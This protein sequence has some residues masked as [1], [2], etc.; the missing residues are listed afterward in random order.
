MATPSA[1]ANALATGLAAMQIDLPPAAQ[2]SLVAYLDLLAKWNRT[3]NLTA[4]R[5]PAA[6]V[7]RHVLDSL[8]PLPFVHGTTLADLGSGAG[9]PGIPLAIARPELAVTLIESN[10]KKARFLREAVRSLPLPNVT[11]AEARVQDATGRFDTVTARAFASLGDMLAW[12]GQLLA[13]GG[14]WLALKGHPDASELAAVPGTFR[15]LAVHAL[16]VPGTPGGRCIVELAH[17]APAPML[18]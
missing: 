7:P 18:R 14:R 1:V 17:A 11:V 2:A 12:G 3:Y 5:D 13:E 6:M 8:A 9:L 15:V 4:V 16:T 10:G